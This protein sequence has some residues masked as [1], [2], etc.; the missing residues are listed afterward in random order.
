MVNAPEDQY[1]AAPN[2]FLNKCACDVLYLPKAI[3]SEYPPI[4]MEVQKNA[5]E[6]YMCRAV[7]YSTLVYEKYEKY[8]VVLIVGVSSVTASINNI[9]APATSHPFSKEIPSLLWAKR[10]LLISS[11]T[12]STIQS[13]EQL[14]PLATIGLFLCSQ[15]LSITHLVSGGQDTTMK[16]LYKVAVKNVQQLLGEEE[17]TTKGI[18][19]ICDNT[20]VQLEKIKSCIQNGNTEFLDKALLYIED[21]SI[22]LKRQEK[23]KKKIYNWKRCN[24][25]PRNPSLKIFE[26]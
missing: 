12:L 1:T 10:C 8:P 25:H 11:T 22:Y 2:E 3:D 14:D 18:K 7:K 20:Y 15:N 19:A 16:L 9:L 4:M 13:T 26:E 5:N 17:E 6:K 24:T 21:T 23:T